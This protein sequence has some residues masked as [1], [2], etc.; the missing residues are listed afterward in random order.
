MSA[1]KKNLSGPS[2]VEVALAAVLSVILGCALG[3]ALLVLKP[4]QTVKSIPKDAASNA[5]FYIEG[6]R[7]FNASADLEAKRKSFIDGESVDLSEGELNVF[8]SSLKKSAAPAKPGD[9]APAADAKVVDV[10]ALNARLFGTKIQLGDTV[11]ISLFGASYSFIVQATGGF[12]KDGPTFVF[13]PEQFY[14]GGCPMDRLIVVKDILL[15]KLLLAQAPPDDLVA[16][17][18]KLSDVSVTGTTLHLKMP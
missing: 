1:K 7:D 3:A 5:V 12:V 16:P 18:G 14:V 11:T 10:G 6:S 4:V 15:K 2:T 8:L 13:E 9:K 17:W